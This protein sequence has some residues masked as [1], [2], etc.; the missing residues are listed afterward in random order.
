[1]SF[2]I[3]NDLFVVHVFSYLLI[4]TFCYSLTD[5]GLMDLAFDSQSIE[6]QQPTPLEKVKVTPGQKVASGQRV[7][8]Q[9]NPAS[10]IVRKPASGAGKKKAVDLAAVKAGK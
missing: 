3:L 5:Y 9:F 1:M 2:L 8:P 4:T 6:P 10:R 7:A